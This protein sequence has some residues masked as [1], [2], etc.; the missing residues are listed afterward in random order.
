MEKGWEPGGRMNRPACEIV[1]DICFSSARGPP[2]RM[3]LTETTQTTT[4]HARQDT[5]SNTLRPTHSE[6][7]LQTGERLRRPFW[8]E[9]FQKS[10][11]CSLHRAPFMTSS[12]R[13][14]KMIQPD[15]CL[16][17]PGDG[18]EKAAPPPPPSL[19]RANSEPRPADETWTGQAQEGHRRCQDLAD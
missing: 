6:S 4:W 8:S 15:S 18:V 13:F 1:S 10:P 11:E 12:C 5:N 7:Q 19:L 16:S 17:F 9:F 2:E 3:C 14:L